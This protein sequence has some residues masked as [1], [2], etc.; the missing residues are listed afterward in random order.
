MMAK[1]DEEFAPA[2]ELLFALTGVV[3]RRP[4]NRPRSRAAI[5]A[6]QEIGAELAKAGFALVVY[7][8]NDPSLEPHPLAIA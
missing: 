4:S 7:F 2:L 6:A 8:S 5:I 1:A 3:I